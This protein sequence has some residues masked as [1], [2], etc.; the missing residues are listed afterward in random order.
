MRDQTKAAHLRAKAGGFEIVCD[1]AKLL[2]IDLKNT[3]IE[4]GG[5]EF[6]VSVLGFD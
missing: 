1:W 2:Q 6:G 5:G 3:R 4:C